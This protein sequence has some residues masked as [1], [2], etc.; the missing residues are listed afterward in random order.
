MKQ[1]LPHM[2]YVPMIDKNKTKVYYLS[3]TIYQIVL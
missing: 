2:S 1:K 3:I